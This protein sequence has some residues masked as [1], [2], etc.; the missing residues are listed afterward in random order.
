VALL[1]SVV[2]GNVVEV[3]TTDDEGTVHLGRDD[4]SGQDT[5]TDGDE[6]SEGALLVC[7]ADIE[8][9]KRSVPMFQFSRALSFLCR[10]PSFLQSVFHQVTKTRAPPI[11]HFD[12][13]RFSIFG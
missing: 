13:L 8:L 11:S 5:S 4:L 10:F 6:S 2:L 3:V 1:V 12:R 7:R 9:A